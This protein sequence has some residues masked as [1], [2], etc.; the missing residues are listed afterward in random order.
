MELILKKTG[1]RGPFEKFNEE[2]EKQ[3]RTGWTDNADVMSYLYTGTPA[4]KTDFTRTGKR[5][6]KG[7][8]NDGINSINRYFI[9]AFTD[10]YYH[11]CI[12]VCTTKLQPSRDTFRKR[13]SF[14]P[15]KFLTILIFVLT[16]ISHFVFKNLVIS[17]LNQS[18]LTMKHTALNVMVVL[19]T[20]LAGVYS[21]L[22]NGRKFV[23]D[24]TRYV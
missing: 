21:I 13:S 2:L 9:N 18:E 10:G 14:E 11:D 23:D 6:Y 5:T 20:F 12:D 24:S 17:Q 8:I 7:A 16:I 15:I 3:F 1:V 4:L 22:N 19:G